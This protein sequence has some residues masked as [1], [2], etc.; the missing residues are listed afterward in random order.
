MTDRRRQRLS[1]RDERGISVIELVIASALM[2][3]IVLAVLASL[4]SGTKTE[5]ST[6]AKSDALIDIRGGVTRF[7]KDVR[8]ATAINGASSSGSTIE[9][10]T[11]VLG[12][13]TRL[14]YD[15]SGGAFRRQVCTTLT[16]GASCGGTPAPLV[17][18]VTSATPFCYNPPGCTTTPPSDI[19]AVRIALAGNPDVQVTQPLSIT[20]DVQLRN[21]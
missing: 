17:L 5:R 6:Q 9:M 18:R 12:T 11:L 16:L 10:Q 1:I 3:V 13:P 4:D 7:T 2:L 14:I 19:S 15:V 8:Q 21:L 20:T